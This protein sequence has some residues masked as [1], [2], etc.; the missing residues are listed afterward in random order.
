VRALG[1]NF[2]VA[3][4]VEA[5]ERLPFWGVRVVLP[6]FIVGSTGLGLSYPQKGAILTVWAIVQCLVPMVSGGYAEAYGYRRSLAVALGLNTLGYVLMAQATGFASMLSAAVCVATGTAVFKPPVQGVV[7][8][9]VSTGNSGLGFGIFYWVVN[10]GG[11]VGPL[12]ASWARGNEAEPTWP[13]VFYGAAAFTA[14]NFV[15]VLVLLREPTTRSATRAP[16]PVEVFRQTIA[17]LWNDRGLLRF[18]LLFSGF[19]LLFMQL[20]DL[21]PNFIDEWVDTRAV[22]AMLTRVWGDAAS[23]WITADGSAKPEILINIDSAAILLLVVPLSWLFAR[24]PMMVDLIVGMVLSGLALVGA[25]ATPVGWICAGFIFVFAIGEI[26]CSPKYSEY[27]GLAAPPDKKALYMG[28]SNI[29]FAIGW[30][31]GSLLSNWLYGTFA[32]RSALARRYL[33]EELQQSRERVDG[34][35]AGDVL[36]DLA[37]RLGVSG[38]EATRVLWNAYH[39]WVVWLLLGAVGAASLVGIIMNHLRSRR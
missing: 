15:P 5:L 22:G 12:L 13:R 32:S 26:M 31:G 33:V 17:V 16:G 38:A 18:L 35:P 10:V 11:F 8:R 19:W 2:W 30:A 1:T 14:L 29:P 25:G 7:A 9:S 27:I 21:M 3:N 23:G 28:Y 39:P 34:I 37:A 4:L 6:V 24:L 20:W 36:G